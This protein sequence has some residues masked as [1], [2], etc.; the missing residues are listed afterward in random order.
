MSSVSFRIVLFAQTGPRLLIKQISVLYVADDIIVLLM[1]S[2]CWKYDY[3][4]ANHSD[5]WEQQMPAGTRVTIRYHY[6]S[7]RLH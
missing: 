7:V 2:L 3:Y 5:R 1:Q 4:S 6:V